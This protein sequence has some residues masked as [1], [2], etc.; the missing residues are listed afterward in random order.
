MEPPKGKQPSCHRLR[1]GRHPGRKH[2]C[3]TLV[4]TLQPQSCGNNSA[5]RARARLERTAV[6]AEAFGQTVGADL[7]GFALYVAEVV[8]PRELERLGGKRHELSERMVKIAAHTRAY[9]VI[10]VLYFQPV[11]VLL[12]EVFDTE[13]RLPKRDF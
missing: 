8:L 4:V 7:E 11:P 12:V 5:R 2:R 10:R 6:M 3:V 13:Q 9:C 1:R